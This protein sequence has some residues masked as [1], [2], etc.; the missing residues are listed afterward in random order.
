MRRTLALCLLSSIAVVLACPRVAGAQERSIRD[1]LSFLVTSQAVPTADVAKDRE[2]ADATRDTL[3][4]AMLVELATL[5]LPTSSS[6]FTYRFNPELGTLV[7]LS[8]SFGPF[9]VDRA[10]TA[11]TGQVETGLT[12]RYSV[13]TSLNGRHLRDGTLVTAANQFR[14]EADPFDVDTLTLRVATSTTTLFANVGVTDWLD[15]GGTVPVVRFDMSGERVN[16]YRGAQLVQARAVATSTDLADI[17][18]RAKAQIVRDGASGLATGLEVRLPTGNPD[19][20]SGAGRAGIKMSLIGSLAR[21]PVELHANGALAEGGISH[22][23]ALGGALVIAA[24]PRVTLSAELLWRRVGELGRIA[25]VVVPHPVFTGVDTLRLTSVGN[26]ASSATTVGGIRWN[27][28]RTWLVNG[29]VALAATD[30]GLR[31]KPVPTVSLDYSFG[32]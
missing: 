2:A 10:I 18:I 17:A 28:T 24:T 6:A 26:D 30:G 7:R 22:Q 8:E 15:I 29:Y 4:R 5:P 9:L 1:I 32:S 25:D 27:V 19:N 21:G 12:Y 31:A 16:T 14:D 3:A 20:L 23:I 13:F 11:G